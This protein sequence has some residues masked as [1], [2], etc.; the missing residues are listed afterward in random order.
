MSGFDEKVAKIATA[1]ID[2]GHRLH[3]SRRPARQTSTARANA[4]P[5]HPRAPAPGAGE[6]QI[7]FFRDR[8]P[9]PL[10]HSPVASWRIPEQEARPDRMDYSRERQE[11]IARSRRRKGVI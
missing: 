2:Q 10:T 6:M 3:R 1:E 8:F 7:R 5:A 4:Q 11:A 9:L